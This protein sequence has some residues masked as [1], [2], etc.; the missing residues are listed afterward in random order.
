MPRLTAADLSAQQIDALRSLAGFGGS[1]AARSL[2]Q[3][4]GPGVEL[5]SARTAVYRQGDT[6][7]LFAPEPVGLSVRFRAEGGARVRLLV[8]FTREG[9][10]RIAAALVGGRASIAVLYRSALAEAANILVSSY[11]SGV[12]AA[13]GL[14]IVPSV[15]E[16]ATGPLAEAAAASFGDLDGPLLLVT[17]IKIAGL[18]L[19]GRIL[20]APEGE[21]LEL[22][23]STLGAL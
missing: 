5:A 9:A 8:Q 6:D 13:V 18:P 17:D 23:L 10:S 20:A 14:T 4:V 16:L 3:L 7:E 22:L 15:P 2:G 12:G 11:L 1:D 21:A 19:A